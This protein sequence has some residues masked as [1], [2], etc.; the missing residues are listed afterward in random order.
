MKLV[1][2][3]FKRLSDLTI[4]IPAE[5][6]GG[7]EV[8]KTSILEA[9]SFCL[10]G[11]D[12]TGA[13]FDQI[14]DNRVDLHE[15]IAD[16]SYF[17]DYGN[18]YRRTVEPVFQT[19]RAGVEEI[20][21]LRSTRCTKNGIDTKDFAGEFG[22]F[23]SFG[24]DFFFNQKEDV[25]RSI[26]IDL[27]KS[28]LPNYDVAEAQLKLKSLKRTQKDTVSDI[29]TLRKVLKGTVDV[30]VPGVD[31]DTER[32]EGEYQTLIKSASE[33][34]QL[35]AEINR[36]NNTVISEYREKNVSLENEIDRNN[37]V[38]SLAKQKKADLENRLSATRELKFVG[39]K[40][41]DTTEL[42]DRINKLNDDL[43]SLRYW[44]DVKDYA[45]E[46]GRE[47]PIVSKNIE[48]LSRLKYATPENMPE[49]EEVSDVCPTCGVSSQSTLDK[50]IEIIQS[51]IKEENRRI[52]ESEMRD[53]NGR[54]LNVKDERDRLTI[55]LNRINAENK[56]QADKEEADRRAFNI[57]K[58]N[59]IEAIEKQIGD[60]Q[61]E[62]LA[63]EK[64]RDAYQKELDNLKEPKLEELPVKGEIPDELIQAH[65]Q[66][67]AQKEAQIGAN[68]INT[69]NAINR[70]KKEAE[71]K[72]K[73]AILMGVEKDVVKLQNEITD[74][75]SNLKNVVA[76]EF[77]GKIEIGVKLQEYVI[78][79]DEYKDVFQITADGKIFPGEC[80]G[81]FRNNV[82]LQ[83]L[84]TL[85]RL[86]GYK[87][88]TIL[89]NAEANTTQP[90]D[91]CGLSLVV[92]RATDSKELTIK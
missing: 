13:T 16:V 84:S 78:T 60:A 36:R 29:D 71:I 66:Y 5:I 65:E 21:I 67:I 17:D 56:K 73:Q 55:Q 37:R 47:N 63:A 62:W 76:K 14:Y 64:Q 1:I 35:T 3:K 22:D 27:M 75:F 23:Y 91:P 53:V 32:M 33:N 54:Y 49:G 82:K 50:S 15:A 81:A 19:S 89:D 4:S 85:Q 52:L 43:S 74:Y 79:R 48:R 58:T 10:T 39:Y 51:G 11:K 68:A 61:S 24:T 18:E 46:H 26:F 6:K 2:H 92:A 90:I 72:E 34:S 40:P 28:L 88:V 12:L 77:A 41:E 45:R 31:G 38:I 7:N 80:N 59:D 20:K 8:G 69:N 30:E 70:A 42:Q 86:K 44:D 9:I 25:Q 57:K 83:V 87:G